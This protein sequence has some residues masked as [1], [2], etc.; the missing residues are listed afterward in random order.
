VTGAGTVMQGKTCV[1]T[2]GTSGIGRETAVALAG[3]GAR[4][5]LVCRDRERGE[6]TV[7]EIAARTRNRD[8][9]LHLADLSSQRDI[10]RVAGELLAT[11][12][13]IHVLV[14]NAGVVN[15]RRTLTA[16]GIEAVF[17][18]NHL[19]PFQLTLLLLDRLRASAPARI[20]TVASEAHRWGRLDLDDLGNARRYRAMQVYGQSKLANILF[21][22]ELA[23]R[24]AGT[25][26][27]ANCLHPGAV[28]TRLGHNNGVIAR[29]LSRLLLPFF[30]TP[31]AG[32]E[33]SIWLASAPEVAGVSGQYF[34]DRARKR[35]SAASYDETT[36]RRLWD[37]S[38]EL[39][40]LD[41]AM[42]PAIG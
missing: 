12:P 39:T 30:R 41:R 21:T 37:A 25:G 19:A 28:A 16:D 11:H 17:A 1:L 5:A 8:V 15:L 3:L 33:T 36:A 27:T 10:R 24:L 13:Q 38:L 22:Y 2:G 4:L 26:V 42:A 7:E 32:A 31:A 35:S 6:G 20:V 29:A 23:R 18:T 34:V 14:N 40:G 9:V